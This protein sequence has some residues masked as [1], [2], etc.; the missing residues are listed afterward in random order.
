MLDQSV[1]VRDGHL[2]LVANPG[3]NREFLHP[4]TNEPVS[5]LDALEAR[6]RVVGVRLGPGHRVMAEPHAWR[7]EAGDSPPWRFAWTIPWLA[8]GDRVID[9]DQDVQGVLVLDRTDTSDFAVR[10]FARRGASAREVVPPLVLPWRSGC[11]VT[12]THDASH[13]YAIGRCGE[14][15]LGFVRDAEGQ[16]EMPVG[17]APARPP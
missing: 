4:E 12:A 10:W 15:T 11:A 13:I 6:W 2:E 3:R 5:A 14:Q 7:I 16:R 8:A 17:G 1:G 9:V